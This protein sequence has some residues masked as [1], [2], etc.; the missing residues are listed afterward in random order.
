MS[1]SFS[2]TE[3]YKDLSIKYNIQ[4]RIIEVIC[5]H[6]FIF[7]KKVMVDINDEKPLMFHYLGKIKLKNR[8]LGKK[9][10]ELDR[11]QEKIDERMIAMGYKSKAEYDAIK[12]NKK[13]DKQF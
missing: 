7:A 2:K 6:P 3:I 12:T 5:N 4:P 13:N 11:I 10:I 1:K 8:F 9:K